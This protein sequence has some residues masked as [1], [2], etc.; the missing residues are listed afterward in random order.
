MLRITRLNPGSHPALLKVEGRIAGPWVGE[1]DRVVRLSVNGGGRV[2]LDVSGVT[3]ADR[4]GTA[5]LRQLEVTGAALHGA[6]AFL[7]NLLRG[8]VDDWS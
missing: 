4:A 2:V 8:E 7:M 1:L 3:F 6:S 5:L